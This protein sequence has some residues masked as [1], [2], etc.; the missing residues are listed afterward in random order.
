M[1]T[2]NSLKFMSKIIIYTSKNNPQVANT[3]IWTFSN[4]CHTQN[5]FKIKF[6]ILLNIL[7]NYEDRKKRKPLL[8]SKVYTKNFQHL[9]KQYR[10]TERVEQ[11]FEQI[12]G[13]SQLCKIDRLSYYLWGSLSSSVK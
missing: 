10:I 2:N 7:T 3:N 11:S 1:P 12:L 8:Y 13:F 6:K 5:N 9:G 4:V